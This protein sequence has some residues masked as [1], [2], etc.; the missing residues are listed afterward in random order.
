M[1][2]FLVTGATGYVGEE[3]FRRLRA[4]GG[5]VTALGRTRPKTDGPFIEADLTDCV[6]L[7]RALA[8]RTFDCVIHLAS[9][10][11]DT[12]NPTQMVQVNINGCQNI[13]E[14]A[15]QADVKR[16]VLASSI[17][18][19][20]WYPATRFSSPDYL[21]VDEE[22]PCRPRDIYSTSKRVQEMLAMTY[23]H[24]YGLPTTAL[25]LTAVVGPR[26]RGGGRGWGQF[27]EQLAGGQRVQVP[28]F[29]ADELC[30]Y[31]D[32]RDVARMCIIASEHPRAPG[33]IFNCC[34]PEPTRGSELRDIIQRL[35]PGIEVDFGFPWSMAQGGELAFDMKK[36]R[37]ILGFWPEYRME[38]SIRSIQE[39][40]D[41]G[42]LDQAVVADNS[43]ESGVAAT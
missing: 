27:A 6:G 11:G 9:L 24:Q 2:T 33:Q 7:H 28:H 26:G 21:P 37:D 15:R 43:Y 35:A 42:G 13:L 30:H 29:T 23:Y 22:H 19:Y 41:S 4:E 34:G 1:K 20:E 14:Y 12:G 18:A 8:G 17:S 36:A 40:V 10:P 32:I 38:D 39:W 16:F 5:K 25:R 3:V 31:V